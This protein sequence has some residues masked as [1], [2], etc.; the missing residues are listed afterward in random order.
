M[1]IRVGP[2]SACRLCCTGTPQYCYTADI[3]GSNLCTSVLRV[4]VVSQSQRCCSTY[5]R[6]YV[7]TSQV[8]VSRMVHGAARIARRTVV[9][10]CSS[11]K[12]SMMMGVQDLIV[13]NVEHSLPR[14]RETIQ[15]TAVLSHGSMA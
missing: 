1:W 14:S 9:P 8:G 2:M 12:T 5:L 15:R 4:Y 3:Y 13:S 10:D 11:L 6:L 7:Q